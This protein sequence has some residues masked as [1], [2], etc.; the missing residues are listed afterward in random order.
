MITE[1][2]SR[3]IKEKYINSDEKQVAEKINNIA[4]DWLDLHREEVYNMKERI[5]RK[6]LKEHIHTV[7]DNET[8]ATSGLLLVIGTMIL[9]QIIVFVIS[10]II[11][12]I[13]IS[14]KKIEEGI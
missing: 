6:R 3:D 2:V 11:N 10:S 5:I 1:M 9:R 14:G 4:K 13:V 8:S 7:L 12:H